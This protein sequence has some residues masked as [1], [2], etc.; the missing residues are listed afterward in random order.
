MAVVVGNGV[1][2]NP[3][4]TIGS[5][6]WESIVVWVIIAVVIV[7]VILGLIYFRKPVG[8]AAKRG[9]SAVA[10]AG[11]RAAMVML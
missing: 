9:G 1:G 7:G 4:I 3:Y 8:R 2:Q 5:I 10:K 6:D 11:K